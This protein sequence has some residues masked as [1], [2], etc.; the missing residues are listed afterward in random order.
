MFTR[1]SF[2]INLTNQ[3][4]VCG[5][6]VLVD[7]TFTSATKTFLEIPDGKLLDV[8]V[9]QDGANI[10]ME[11]Q[12]AKKVFYVGKSYYDPNNYYDIGIFNK[13][14]AANWTEIT[15]INA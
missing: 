2:L 1:F 5:N 10:L 8:S 7:R 9:N 12:G 3:I 11:T 14:V 15:T 6:L 4:E 13:D